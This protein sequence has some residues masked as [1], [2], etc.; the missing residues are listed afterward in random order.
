VI[1]K[2][3]PASCK[4]CTLVMAARSLQVLHHRHSK[5][6]QAVKMVR[7]NFVWVAQVSNTRPGVGDAQKKSA[8]SI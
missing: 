7:T 1:V 5:S 2:F 4:K 6:A 8:A 3:C